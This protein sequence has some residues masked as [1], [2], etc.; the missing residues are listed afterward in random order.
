MIIK[1]LLVKFLIAVLA[2]LSYACQ[3]EEQVNPT[4]NVEQTSLEEV[5][6]NSY[7]ITYNNNKAKIKFASKKFED[8]NKVVQ[9]Y[10]KNF[11]NK[12]G[13]AA[14]NITHTYGS[15]L[16]G[17]A[18]ILSEEEVAKLKADPKVASVEKNYIVTLDYQESVTKDNTKAQSIPWGI[19][20]TG[21]ASGAGKTAWVL[22]TGID[23][24]HP[25][26]N[27]DTQRSRSFVPEFEV[28][29][30]RSRSF[31]GDY[32]SPNDLGGH[33]THVAGTIAALNNNIGVVGVA[34][35][36]TVVSV[37]VLTRRSIGSLAGIINGVDYVTA[38]AEPGDVANLS[39]GSG[40]DL[41][42][43]NAVKRLA[44]RGVL[45]SIAAGNSRGNVKNISPARV[46]YQ[47]VVTVSAMDINDRFAN[48]FP[49]ST[50]GSNYG[51]MIDYAGPGSNIIS[52]WM[53]GGYATISGTSMAAPHIAGLLLLRG[54]TDLR[55][56]GVVNGDRDDTPDP[57][58]IR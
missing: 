32:G 56:D 34:Y 18:A 37:K 57:I 31:A 54:S 46:D 27:V 48:Y 44:D 43:D 30:Q 4:K 35:G 50:G 25:D 7:I 20:R 28:N 13:I 29:T 8:R 19:N 2:V 16:E 26:L 23:L 38:N 58:A 5:V 40:P 9:D 6:P 42:L 39:L 49:N 17:F 1:N 10:T 53:D 41:I 55:T 33:G 11:L 12:Y 14:K 21:S 24:D 36:A 15:A 47:N 51:S 52:T 45:V 3:Q 22:D